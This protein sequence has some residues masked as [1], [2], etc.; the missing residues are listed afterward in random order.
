MFL[1]YLVVAKQSVWSNKTF[2]LEATILDCKLL[3]VSKLL[4]PFITELSL[5]KQY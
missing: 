4:L 3:T 1:Q 5:I 2:V